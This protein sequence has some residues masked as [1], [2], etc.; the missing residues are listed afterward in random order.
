MWRGCFDVVHNTE[1]PLDRRNDL[2]H[3]V[4]TPILLYSLCAWMISNACK[5]TRQPLTRK[6]TSTSMAQSAE[7]LVL[8]QKV[9]GSPPCHYLHP[10]TMFP[11]YPFFAAW[12]RSECPKFRSYHS[13]W[14]Q[15]AGLRAPTLVFLRLTAYIGLLLLLISESSPP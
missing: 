13:A 15:K 12:G 14:C 6:R 2:R 11:W 3:N 4:C 8:S 9:A 10:G 1:F 5:A 7:R